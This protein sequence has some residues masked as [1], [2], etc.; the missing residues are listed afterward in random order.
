MM[1]NVVFQQ[2]KVNRAKGKVRTFARLSPL[3]LAL[4]PQFQEERL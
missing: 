2:S 1:K 4:C 3:P